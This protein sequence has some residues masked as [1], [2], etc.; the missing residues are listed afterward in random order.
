MGEIHIV[1][2]A[3]QLA[4]WRGIPI[5]NT[6]LTSAI[7]T[8]LLITAAFAA[9]RN[10]RLVP[11]RVQTMLEAVFDYVFRY[12]AE[13]LESEKLARRFFPLLMTI[14]V[15]I[16]AANILEFTPGIGSVG[17][18]ER[19][20]GE[21][22]FVPL[23]RSVNT[24]MNTPLALAIIAFLVIEITGVAAIGFFKYWKKFLNLR[25][26]LGLFVGLIELMS[27][28]MRLITYSFR[29]FGNIFAG[30]ALIM[31]AIAFVP[32]FLPVPFMLFEVFV[33]FIQA[34]IF[35]LLTLFFIKIAIIEP[36]H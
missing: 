16:F 34:A 14:F 20:N 17:F 30:E 15:F 26:P 11:G 3:E 25:S 35:S 18:F 31:I 21:E 4:E 23:L 22:A 13:V 24:D 8:L 27:E 32:F 1:L 10:V 29:L 12:T 7:V 5:T 28:V 2:A 19:H 36:E 6:L 9:S 33:G